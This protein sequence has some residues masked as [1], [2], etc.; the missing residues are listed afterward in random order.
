MLYIFHGSDHTALREKLASVR[1]TLHTKRPDAELFKLDDP[2]QVTP[3][4]LEELAGGQG[5]F[6]QKYIVQ[7]DRVIDDQKARDAISDAAEML[8]SSD[9][10]FLLAEDQLEQQTLTKL[11]GHAHAVH[12]F[13]VK[14]K[15]ANE[16][17]VFTLTDALGRRDK[18][19]LWVAYHKAL[20]SG[21]DAEELHGIL[22]W[23]IKAMLLASTCSTAQEAGMKD[24]PFKKAKEF[25]ARFSHDDLCE[26]SRNLVTCFHEARRGQGMLRDNLEQWIL[27][28][29]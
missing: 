14:K 10:V 4:A 15:E 23:Q 26:L 9:N 3:A 24:F 27:R 17:N 18:K 11:E 28:L 13:P 12:H 22:F 6:E 20:R 19:T 7:L 2:E 8:G 5:L 21:K 1:H 29:S 25:A 16:F